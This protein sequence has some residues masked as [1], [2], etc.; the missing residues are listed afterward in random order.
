VINDIAHGH[1]DNSI[2]S[3]TPFMA[4]YTSGHRYMIILEIRRCD[5]ENESGRYCNEFGY[6]YEQKRN[7][8]F[9]SF[10]KLFDHYTVRRVGYV[11]I[12]FSTDMYFWHTRESDLINLFNV[13]YIP[14]VYTSL[15][16]RSTFYTLFRNKCSMTGIS[17]RAEFELWMWV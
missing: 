9:D 1:N 7:C 3:L 4:E 2:N 14:T 16:T 12:K 15:S 6:M 5:M 17:R 8:F 13:L 10:L 11:E